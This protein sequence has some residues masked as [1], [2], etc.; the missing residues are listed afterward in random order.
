MAG[1]SVWKGLGVAGSTSIVISD[2][3]KKEIQQDVEDLEEEEE[4]PGWLP[5]GWIMEV[6]QGDDGTIYRYY[7]SPISGLTFTMKSEFYV[8]PPAGVR[9]FSKEDVL[10]YIN[11]SEITGFDTNGECDTRTKDNILANVEFN[12]H[13]L[14]EGWVKEVV[15]RKTKTGVIRKDPY[16]TDPVNN[17]SFRTRKSAMLYVQTGKV[18][19]RAFIQRTSVHD[20]Y[21]FEK[22]ADL[23][24]SLKKR[25]DFAARTNRKSRRSL[26][27]KNSSLTEK[28]LSD[29]ES[30]Y[31][32]EDG[33][34]SDDL[35]DSSSE[36]KKNKGKLEK[37]TCKTKKSV[38]FN[39]AKRPVGRPSKRSTEEMPRDVEIKQ[40]SASSEEYWC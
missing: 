29:E 8:Y 40:E 37:T 9:L 18:P 2:D 33:D 14:P 13:S 3:E 6:Y 5:D 20:L 35:S 19:K 17:Y 38:S 39:T 25:L 21:S 1:P 4:R 26:K 24:E 22:S 16:F 31:K 12:P 36:V 15:F 34:S 10:L 11:K 30:S 28:S 27:S 23:H 7:T 32:S